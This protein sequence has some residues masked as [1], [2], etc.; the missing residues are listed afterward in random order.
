MRN[1]RRKK[2][3]KAK[4]N[5]DVLEWICHLERKN[6]SDKEWEITSW[7]CFSLS[8]LI[9]STSYTFSFWILFS[10]SLSLSQSKRKWLNEIDPQVLGPTW[11]DCLCSNFSQACVQTQQVPSTGYRLLSQMSGLWPISERPPH[12]NATC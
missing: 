3:R 9:L 6:R 2:E 5:R 1:E 12:R 7:A 10:L 8:F 11:I 4:L